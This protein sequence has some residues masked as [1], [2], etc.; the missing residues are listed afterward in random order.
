MKPQD[1]SLYNLFI[2]PARPL[3]PRSSRIG[4]EE[5]TLY[6][7]KVMTPLNEQETADAVRQLK[8]EG[9]EFDRGVLPALLCQCR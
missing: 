8:A 1:V 4:I 2:P 9:V 6:D 3:I 5:R 7:G